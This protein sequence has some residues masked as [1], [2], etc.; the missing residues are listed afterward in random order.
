MKK[1]DVSIK[2]PEPTTFDLPEPSKKDVSGLVDDI[3]VKMIKNTEKKIDK[4]FPD[5]FQILCAN[6]NLKKELE[7]KRACWKDGFELKGV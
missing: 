3:G 1:M 7:R 5:G 4:N 2:T 6:H